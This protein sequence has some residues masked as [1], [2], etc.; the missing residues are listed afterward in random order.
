[1]LKERVRYSDNGYIIRN[2]GLSLYQP[3]KVR[4]FHFLSIGNDSFLETG[5]YYDDLLNLNGDDIF[6]MKTDNACNIVDPKDTV[7][8]DI[9]EKDMAYDGNGNFNLLDMETIFGEFV[10]DIINEVII[11]SLIGTAC[12][13]KNFTKYI[14]SQINVL[15]NM[16]KVDSTSWNKIVRVHHKYDDGFWTKTDSFDIVCQDRYSHGILKQKRYTIID[17]DYP[18]IIIDKFSIERD[19]KKYVI[20]TKMCRDNNFLREFIRV[21]VIDDN[22]LF[23]TIKPYNFVANCIKYI[24]DDANDIINACK[25]FIDKKGKDIIWDVY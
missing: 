8:L 13:V 21:H 10:I 1:M 25:K 24:S 3:K 5:Y 23:I 7:S 14:S 16:Y 15:E 20:L 18:S 9:Y 22:K 17:N 12:S 2:G 11:K 6:S 19:G 4:E